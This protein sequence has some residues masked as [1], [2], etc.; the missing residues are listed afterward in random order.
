DQRIFL[1]DLPLAPI[2]KILKRTNMRVSNGAVKEFTIYVEQ[3][4]ADIAAESVANAKR[5]KRKTVSASDV[6]AAKRKLL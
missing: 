1:M 4:I 2:K 5:N 6:L 3:I